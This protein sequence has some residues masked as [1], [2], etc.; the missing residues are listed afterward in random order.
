MKGGSESGPRWSASRRAAGNRRRILKGTKGVWKATGGFQGIQFQLA[1]TATQIEAARLMVYNAARLKDGTGF[2]KEAAMA[3]Y[4]SSQVA[5]HVTS[6]VVEIYGGYG[7]TKDYPGRKIFPGFEDRQDL[8]RHVQ[9]A[10]ADDRQVLVTVMKKVR[11]LYHD[12]CF[13]GGILRC[14]LFPLL[15]GRIDRSCGRVRRPDPQS[16]TACQ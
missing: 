5:E 6:L 14:G 7:Y 3:K 4:F 9:Y 11:V 1:E 16:G 8:R 12:N 13:D 10:A 2:L 15:L